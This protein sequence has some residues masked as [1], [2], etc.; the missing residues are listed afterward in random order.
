MI[1]HEYGHHVQNLLGTDERVGR[2]PRRA[3]SRA[4]CG[5]S[6]RPTATPACGPRTRS[7][8]GSSSSSPTRTSRD[9]L[10]AAAAIGDDRIQERSGGR[11]DPETWTH[12]SSEQRQSWFTTGYR[13]ATR[14]AATRSPLEHSKAGAAARRARA[15]RDVRSLARSVS[16]PGLNRIHHV[17]IFTAEWWQ[18]QGTVR[19]PPLYARG[20][21][22]RPYSPCPLPPAPARSPLTR[23]SSR[24][25]VSCP[26]CRRARAPPGS[27]A[28]RG[29]GKMPG[30][31]S[32]ASACPGSSSTSTSCSCWRSASSRI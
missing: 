25:S 11:V 31:P 3:R 14:T 29:S 23:T 17:A 18:V 8:P 12:G 1:A 22:V 2:R 20:R 7:R 19:G 13:R 26:R 27:P 28:T 24:S 5:S 21:P 4:R 30:C 32:P 10:D 16:I 15:G 9:G 6:C